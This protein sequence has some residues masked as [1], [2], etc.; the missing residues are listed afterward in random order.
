MEKKKK[1]QTKRAQYVPER[2]DTR[3]IPVKL[4]NSR[5]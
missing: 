4:S 5:I 3:Y 1:V 2:T